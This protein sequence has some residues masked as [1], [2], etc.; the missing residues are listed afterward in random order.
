MSR[1][2]NKI[3]L[4]NT[5]LLVIVITM[6]FGQMFKLHLHLDHSH[7][8]DSTHS[9][10]EK[11]IDFHLATLNHSDHDEDIS[12]H[13]THHETEIELAADGIIN[14]LEI[15]KTLFWLVL[16][17]CSLF[18]YININL[19]S[20]WFTRQRQFFNSSIHFSPPLRAPPLFNI[21]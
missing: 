3:R 13:L 11:T 9:H 1:T 15:F 14:K 20:R 19:V 4:Q 18:L 16:T 12:S 5:L 7:H 10:V 21:V 17:V 2:L 8:H 6:I